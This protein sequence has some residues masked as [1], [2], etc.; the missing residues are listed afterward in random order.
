MN[1]ISDATLEVLCK[2]PPPSLHKASDFTAEI[3]S[4]ESELG[5]E[6]S[7]PT[8]SLSDNAKRLGELRFLATKLAQGA[9]PAAVVVPAPS[10]PATVAA[11]HGLALAA[12][13]VRIEGQ[14]DAPAELSTKLK[15]RARM[16]AALKIQGGQA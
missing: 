3:H 10:A 8:Y 5:L 7:R 13:A 11:L 2:T 12:S 16:L 1:R 9:A 6:R 14:D 4:L 15:G